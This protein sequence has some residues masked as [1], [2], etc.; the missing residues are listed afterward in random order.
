[1]NIHMKIEAKGHV[2][3]IMQRNNLLATGTSAFYNIYRSFERL[4]SLEYKVQKLSKRAR[5]SLT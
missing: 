2:L 4:K 1:M 5:R 3:K